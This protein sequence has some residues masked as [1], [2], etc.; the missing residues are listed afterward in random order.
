MTDEHQARTSQFDSLRERQL[1]AWQCGERLLVETLVADMTLPLSESELLELIFAEVML[2]GECGEVCSVE[3][4]L[5]RF[6]QFVDSLRRLFSIQE[7][8]NGDSNR[9]NDSSASPVANAALDLTQL[10]P[11]E[12]EKS[13]AAVPTEHHLLFAVLAFESDLLS[14]PQLTAACRVWAADK[15]QSLADLLVRRGWISAED[16]AFIEKQLERKLAKH[17]DDPRV[18]LN[19]VT[20]GDVCDALKALADADINQSLSSWPA[21]GPVLVE[22]VGESSTDSSAKSRYTWLS[23]VGKGGLG[24][25]WLAR[26]NYLAREVALKE[27]VPGSASKDAIRM[28]IKEA[29][30]TGQLQHPNIVPV[31]EVNRGG[32]PFYTMKLVK[33]E[34]LSKAIQ[35]HHGQ[36]AI[37]SPKVAPDTLH[38]FVQTATPKSGGAAGPADHVAAMSLSMLRLM[39]VF[40]NV[41]DALAYAHSR[42]VIHRDL[43]PQNIV[44]G[45]YGEA[46]VLDWGLARKLDQKDNDAASIRVTGDAQTEATQAGSIMGSPPYMAPEQATGQIDMIDQRTDIYGLG[47]ILFE[48]LTGRAPHRKVGNESIVNLLHRIATGETPHVRD[49]EPRIPE[50]LDAIC[51]KAMA[52]SC[53]ERY[54]TTKDLKAAILE[55]QVHEESIDLAAT[56]AADLDHARRSNDYQ[57]FSRAMFG[58]EEALRQWPANTR[59]SDGVAET[60]TEYAECAFQRGDYDLALSLLEEMPGKTQRKSQAPA[61]A[62]GVD[63]GLE[64]ASPSHTQN[65]ASQLAALRTKIQL[66][67]TERASRQT[68]IRRLR[69]FGIAASLT[70]AVIATI[71]AAWINLEREAAINAKQRAETARKDESRQRAVAVAAQTEA[72]TA[73]LSVEES[74]REIAKQIELLGLE[75]GLRRL[76]QDKQTLWR[77]ANKRIEPLHQRLSD[78]DTDASM[79]TFASFLQTQRSQFTTE[80]RIDLQSVGPMDHLELVGNVAEFLR[81]FYEIPVHILPAKNELALATEA[82]R[83]HFGHQQWRAEDVISIVLARDLNPTNGDRF[84]SQNASNNAISARLSEDQRPNTFL[85]MMTEKDLWSGELNYVFG[86]NN[87]KLHTAIMS[88][89]R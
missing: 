28:L 58:F 22:S 52:K 8:M 68:R 44:L 41:C 24:K 11:L 85:L 67:A 84:L 3:D 21:G 88:M 57:D 14:L 50:E 54:Q 45:D 34:T 48:I 64:E 37:S 73:K 10:G 40:L 9:P 35:Q 70:A 51:A 77:I 63:D 23:E 7:A 83:E 27:I 49:I 30:I 75:E 72:E 71:A 38:T 25:V 36:F 26:D 82:Q 66:A 86:V 6:P 18:T 4:Y 61:E 80:S 32:R 19:A 78:S 16:R 5:Q 53:V 76:V 42:G 47:A 15:S 12:E 55:F 62:F 20:R 31:Y 1:H 56:A 43:K 89:N 74:Q 65:S 60:R 59:A 13:I 81:R 33:G 87:V 46:I 69:R 29:Q 2:R 39:S 17:Q 79:Q